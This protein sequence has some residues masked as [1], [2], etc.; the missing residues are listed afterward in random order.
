MVKSAWPLV[1]AVVLPRWVRFVCFFINVFLHMHS[2]PSL[3]LF[4]LWSLFTPAFWRNE[5]L[6]ILACPQHF[7]NLRADFGC[8]L[9]WGMSLKSLQVPWKIDDK[10]DGSESA[11]LLF[12][13]LL[14]SPGENPLKSLF[15]EHGEDRC[16]RWRLQA[17]PCLQRC[18]SARWR[19]RGHLSVEQKWEGR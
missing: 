9:V 10:G 4:F 7:L 17:Y 19:Q 14:L 2:V 16:P 1:L 6:S 11:S 8:V 15:I 3:D 18:L 12:S 5:A 13:Y